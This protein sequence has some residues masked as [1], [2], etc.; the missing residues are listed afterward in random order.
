MS[1]WVLL[2]GKSGAGKSTVANHLKARGWDVISAGDVV[3]R[4][5]GATSDTPRHA[6]SDFGRAY[7]SQIGEKEFARRLIVQA[8]PVSKAVVIEGVRPFEVAR[9]LIELIPGMMVVFLDTPDH[10]RRVRVMSR[11][12]LDMVEWERRSRDS[13]EEAVEE[14][15]PLAAIVLSGELPPEEIA[16][17]II[18]AAKN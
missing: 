11:E 2:L 14:L 18:S 17:Q 9:N 7:L 3:R 1:R 4:S 8:S 15:R 6:L 5:M 10:T 12:S 16:D 13:M